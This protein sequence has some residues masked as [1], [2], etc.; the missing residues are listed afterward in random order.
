M[1]PLGGYV[2]HGAFS[3]HGGKKWTS[4]QNDVTESD[5]HWSLKWTMSPGESVWVYRQLHE[6]TQAALGA[7]LGSLSRQNVSNMEHGHRPV[8]KAVAKRLAE[9]F[10]GSVEKVI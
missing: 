6:M 5:W 8:S 2:Y 9:L 10:N 7:K 4:R 3:D 1:Y